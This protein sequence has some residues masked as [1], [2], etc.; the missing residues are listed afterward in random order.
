MTR[1]SVRRLTCLHSAGG[2]FYNFGSGISRLP[3]RRF[4]S[5]LCAAL[6]LS[7]RLRL[8]GPDL[9]LISSDF[10]ACAAAAAPLLLDARCRRAFLR[11]IGVW[12]CRTP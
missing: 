12:L 11:P 2:V 8:D 4:P 5:K 9:P 7:R 1:S 6:A 3:V 10:C